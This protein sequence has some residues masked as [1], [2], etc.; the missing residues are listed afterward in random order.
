MTLNRGP[1]FGVTLGFHEVT[2]RV[3]GLPL[4]PDVIENAFG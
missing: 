4:V 3:E 1:V 2:L